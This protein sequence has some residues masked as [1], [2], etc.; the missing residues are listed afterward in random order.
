MLYVNYISIKKKLEQMTKKKKNIKRGLGEES[1]QV[2]SRNRYSSVIVHWWVGH[3]PDLVNQW[4]C[5]PEIITIFTV[6]SPLKGYFI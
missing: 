6:E 5:F 4:A 3:N 2:E 1:S